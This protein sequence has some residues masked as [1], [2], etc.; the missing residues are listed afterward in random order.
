MTRDPARPGDASL[1]RGESAPRV[2]NYEIGMRIAYDEAARAV[3]I[4]FRGK[5]S[6]FTTQLPR[7]GAIRAGEEYCKAMGWDP[8]VQRILNA[9]P[10]ASAQQARRL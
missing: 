4:T 8:N 5:T 6:S 10:A 9:V 2:T 1:R 7:D 3:T